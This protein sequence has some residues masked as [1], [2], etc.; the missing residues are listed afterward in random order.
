[1]IHDTNVLFCKNVEV[2]AVTFDEMY[3]SLLNKSVNF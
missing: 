2:V 3:A 1:M